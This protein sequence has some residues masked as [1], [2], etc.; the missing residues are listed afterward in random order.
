MTKRRPNFSIHP[1]LAF[2]LCLLV[3][4]TRADDAIPLSLRQAHEAALRNHPRISVADLK[5][6]AAHQ[7][8]REVRSAFFPNVW[9]SAV[10]VGT[11]GDNTR[12]AAIGALNNPSIFERN[13]EGVT[14]SQLLTDFGR[15]ANLT[16]SARLRALAE[17]NNAQ[18]TREQILL[19]VDAAFYAALEAQSV[20][21]VAR[22]TVATRQLF[23]DQVTSLANNKLR[24]ELDVS[25]ASVNL[26][27]GKLL[28]SKAQ[29]DLQAAFSQLTSL[30][31]G[32][33][34]ANY[35]LAEDPLPAELSTNAAVFVEQALQ[36]RPDLLALRNSR[37]A[38]L[39]FSSAERAARYPT[40]AAVGSAGVVPIHDPQ[41]P[42]S[43][44]AGGVTLNL[45]LFAGGLFS[46]R[47]KEAELRAKA[48]EESL[49]DQ[50]NQIIRDV[51]IAWLNSQNAFDR[52]R[53]SA[54]LVKHAS[55]SFDLAQARYQ[56]GA[57]SIVELNQ[58][59]L[60]KISAEIAYANTKYEYLLRRSALNFASGILR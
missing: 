54:Q 53:I 19:E 46:A 41:L 32:R 29:N 26:E 45:P 13:A 35:R 30:M 17:E 40:I 37:D 51:R 11:A 6:L 23:L 42:D 56:N 52:L 3:S 14:I 12:L 59:Q 36:L 60:N 58:A 9:G 39:K 2:F 21:E 8:T 34:P 16:G 31:G 7:V 57:S 4:T 20:S 49:R 5:A 44:A 38:A 25:F 33:N 27:E 10:G 22:Q 24:S 55:R 43:Y 15:T 18:A 50:E 47:Q 48:A 1:L 28:L